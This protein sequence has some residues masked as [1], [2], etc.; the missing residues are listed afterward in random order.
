MK[1][2]ASY[3]LSNSLMGEVIV[4]NSNSSWVLAMLDTCTSVL[5]YY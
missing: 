3:N 4:T 1:F 5:R 2:K